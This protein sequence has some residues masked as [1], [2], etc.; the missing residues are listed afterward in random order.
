MMKILVIANF[1]LSFILTS[2]LVSNSLDQVA[3]A[4]DLSAIK[5][6]ATKLLTG[7]ENSQRTDNN[8]ASTTDNST[9]S[10]SSLTQK[11]TDV[12]GGLLK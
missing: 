1:V 12:L 4:Q 11:A 7:N 5:D 10:D 3:L 8:S 9:S 2:S 6:E